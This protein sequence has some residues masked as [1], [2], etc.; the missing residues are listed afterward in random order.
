MQ[1]IFLI[2]FENF[3]FSLTT[4]CHDDASQFIWI[5]TRGRQSYVVP[6]D[7]EF[8]IQV[9]GR[10]QILYLFSVPGTSDECLVS[11]SFRILSTRIRV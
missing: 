6:E 5:L 9:E 10:M 8:L 11:L 1:S 3:F 4:T 7:F 2:F